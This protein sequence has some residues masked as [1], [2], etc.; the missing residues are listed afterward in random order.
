M[1]YQ[2]KQLTEKPASLIKVLAPALV[3]L[4][5]IQL[6]ANVVGK[7]VDG[8]ACTRVL[9]TKIED[10]NGVSGSWCS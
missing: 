4:C 1:E 2:V 9:A 3:F 7:A 8:G 5:P 10:V 6:P